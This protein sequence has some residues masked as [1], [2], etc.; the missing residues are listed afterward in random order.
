MRRNYIFLALD[1]KTKEIREISSVENGLNCNCVCCVCNTPLEARQGNCNM[2]HFAHTKINTGENCFDGAVELIKKYIIDV[3]V[4]N[5]DIIK[6]PKIEIGSVLIDKNTNRYFNINNELI[7]VDIVCKINKVPNVEDFPI[8]ISV[9]FNEKIYNNHY[10]SYKEGIIDDD[11]AHDIIGNN[12]VS[13]ILIISIHSILKNY[14]KNYHLIKSPSFVNFALD[15]VLNEDYCKIW[16]YIPG[17][18]F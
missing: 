12:P 17:E 9:I 13:G 3:L 4:V 7:K 5:Q 2:W 1:S 11:L 18:D 6:V 8:E 15:S 10:L 14:I 16:M